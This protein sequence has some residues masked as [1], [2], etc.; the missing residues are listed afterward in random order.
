MGGS[1]SVDAGF[2]KEGV[3]QAALQQLAQLVA[4]SNS[5]AEQADFWK[6]FSGNINF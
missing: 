3:N 5:A 6:N 1:G 4:P 2:G